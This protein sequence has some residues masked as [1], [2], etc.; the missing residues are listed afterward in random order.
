M[1]CYEPGGISIGELHL[2]ET[3]SNPAFGGPK[4]NRLFTTA[5]TSVH[6]VH[7]ETQGALL[8]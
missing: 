1:R 3:C 5:S 4:R 7:A 2:P 6:A 8:P